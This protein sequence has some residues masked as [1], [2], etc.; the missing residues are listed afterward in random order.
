MIQPYQALWSAFRGALG[1][2]HNPL[3]RLAC[4]GYGLADEHVNT[5]IESALARTNF[6]VLI[7]AKVLSDEA[8]KRWST[9]NNVIIVTEDRCAIKSEVGPGHPNLWEFEYL[10]QRI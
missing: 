2:D 10:T 4:I 7:F 6:T 1:Q 5:V 3:N 9:K 8:W